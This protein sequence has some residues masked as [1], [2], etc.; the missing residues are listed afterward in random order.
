MFLINPSIGRNIPKELVECESLLLK[1]EGK[2]TR[3]CLETKRPSKLS[4]K[5]ALDVYWLEL[6]LQYHLKSR[7][8]KGNKNDSEL[9][10][11]VAL[12]NAWLQQPQITNANKQRLSYL[13]YLYYTGF[14]SKNSLPS[15]NSQS[16][17]RSISK[18]HF[19]IAFMILLTFATASVI[20]VLFWHYFNGKGLFNSDLNEQLALRHHVK[21]RDQ[22]LIEQYSRLQDYSIAN[23]HLV[24]APLARLLGLVEL[25]KDE[26][27]TR[28]GK[29]Y[30]QN[31]MQSCQELDDWT[32]KMDNILDTDSSSSEEESKVS[33]L[34]HFLSIEK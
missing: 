16:I 19:F 9:M 10:D 29:F 7:D 17:E 4:S 26:P 13:V 23:S 34:A 25:L 28:N 22:E 21:E 15:V 24:R 33:E 8:L 11:A 27:L 14:E 5:V 20:M 2:E 31:I 30:L 1:G 18:N 6:W 32:I 12:A 3:R